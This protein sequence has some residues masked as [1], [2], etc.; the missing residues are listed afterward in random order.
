MPYFTVNTGVSANVDGIAD[1]QVLKWD[2]ASQTFVPAADSTGTG[3]KHENFELNATDIANKYVDLSE[4]P[5][6]ITKTRLEV[7]GGIEQDFGTDFTVI[8]DGSELKRVS[9]NG[10]GL[11]SL[12]SDGDEII[13]SYS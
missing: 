7:I 6:D 4:A 3:N 5:G 9:W 13:V 1:G 2:E 10:L 11:E 8:S 12:L